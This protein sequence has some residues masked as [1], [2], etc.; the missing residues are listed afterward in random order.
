MM[1][2]ASYQTYYGVHL[3]NYAETWGGTDYHKL[4]VTKYFPN[5]INTT[6]ESDLTSTSNYYFLFPIRPKSQ[7][8]VN[9]TARGHFRLHNPTVDSRTVYMYEIALRKIDDTGGSTTL[10]NYINYVH[11]TI[12]SEGYETLPIVLNVDKKFVEKNEKL[13][14]WIFVN[15]DDEICLSHVNDSRYED[16]K[17]TVP[18]ATATGR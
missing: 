9:G 5:D 12:N 11:Q 14:L 13:A 3:N 10:A 1:F 6:D 7:Y 16:V 15:C 8:Y 4:M 18:F 17:I 2:P